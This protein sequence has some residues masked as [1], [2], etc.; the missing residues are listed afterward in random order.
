M[1]VT[2]QLLGQQLQPGV[3]TSLLPGCYSPAQTITIRSCYHLPLQSIYPCQCYQPSASSP[4]WDICSSCLPP[5][6]QSSYFTRNGLVILP[7]PIAE[8]VQVL[9]LCIIPNALAIISLPADALLLAFM[10]SPSGNTLSPVLIQSNTM[11]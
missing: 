2:T 7:Q 11:V 5:Q 1:A 9:L 10:W 6:D 4:R 8:T 3:Q